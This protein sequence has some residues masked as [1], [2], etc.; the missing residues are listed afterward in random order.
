VFPEVTARLKSNSLTNFANVMEGEILPWLTNA[1]GFLDLIILVQARW[2]RVTSISLLD[3]LKVM[4]RL[5]TQ[6]VSGIVAYSG[7]APG[8]DPYL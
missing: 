2:Q 7:T 3:P 4:R 6:S 1:G 5:T 8:R